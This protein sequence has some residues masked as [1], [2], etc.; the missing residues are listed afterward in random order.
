MALTDCIILSLRV[1]DFREAV[2]RAPREKKR[3]DLLANAE[4]CEWQRCGIHRLHSL[5]IFSKCSKQFLS[6]LAQTAESALCFHGSDI[7]S[8]ED[9]TTGLVLFMDGHGQNE[10]RHKV[11]APEVLSSVNWLGDRTAA[12]PPRRVKAKEVCQILRI[13]QPKLLGLLSRHPHE[14]AVMVAEAH[15][16][17]SRKHGGYGSRQAAFQR[18]LR[19]A[20][21][22]GRGGGLFWYCPFCDDLGES[23]LQ[24]LITHM[25]CF[26]LIPGQHLFRNLDGP[27]A[28]FLVVLT[29]GRLRAVDEALEA[30]LILYPPW[31]LFFVVVL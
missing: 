31:E 29:R 22:G 14:T 2:A 15:R 11:Q 4:Y 18:P 30:P 21:N 27:N 13:S 17:N 24:E 19:D 12:E 23:F 16:M 26:K 6:D 25:E 10:K 7:I 28:D 1:E 8:A 20:A 3:F 9:P 5:E